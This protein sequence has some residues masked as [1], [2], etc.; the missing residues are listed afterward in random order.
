V[1]D[2]AWLVETLTI[3]IASDTDCVF[4]LPAKLRCCNFAFLDTKIDLTSSDEIFKETTLASYKLTK[5]TTSLAVGG[6]PLFLPLSPLDD[7]DD[8]DDDDDA[9]VQLDSSV[10]IAAIPSTRRVGLPAA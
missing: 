10:L 9:E 6:A 7:D 4:I 5:A 3:F 8:D 1:V 2:F